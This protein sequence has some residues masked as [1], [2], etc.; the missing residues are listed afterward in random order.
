VRG[1]ERGGDG[2]CRTVVRQE[3]QG[4]G[5][6]GGVCAPHARWTVVQR[7]QWGVTFVRRMPAGLWSSV[8]SGN[9]GVGRGQVSSLS[10]ILRCGRREIWSILADEDKRRGHSYDQASQG[11]Q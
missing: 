11:V 2:G 4:G 10:Y 9:D 5:P 6:E 7:E 1:R 3:G 8:S